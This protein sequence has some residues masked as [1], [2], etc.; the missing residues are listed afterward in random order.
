MTHWR[1]ALRFLLR[2]PG[3]TL[4]A[5][6]LLGAGIGANATLFSIVDTVL[7]KP[8]PYPDADRLTFVYEADPASRKKTS[9]VAPVRLEEWNRLNRSFSAIAGYYT[10]NV[11]DITES[12]PERLAA[13]HV[14]LR[15]FTVFGRRHCWAALSI[16]PK[17]PMA[18][19]TP[20]LSATACGRGASTVT[21]TLSDRS[22]GLAAIPIPSSA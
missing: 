20:W 22:C 16:G 12:M 7:L 6:T 14:S 8:L 11:T 21:R 18:G 4:A 3:F 17:R 5:V 13:R 15:Y 19:R 9:L 2:R 10:E 1:S